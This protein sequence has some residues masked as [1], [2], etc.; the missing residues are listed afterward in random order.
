MLSLY[1]LSPMAAPQ[2]QS[3]MYLLL[4]STFMFSLPSE[5]TTGSSRNLQLANHN[6][7]HIN[8]HPLATMS[9]S[10]RPTCRP[11]HYTHR[12]I[13]NPDPDMLCNICIEPL[14]PG[15]RAQGCLAIRLHYRGHYVGREC[16]ATWLKKHINICPHPN[17]PLRRRRKPIRYVE[18]R[19]ERGLD[20]L[21]STRVFAYL[22]DITVQFNIMEGA[23]DLEDCFEARRERRLTYE[24][25]VRVLRVY[26]EGAVAGVAFMLYLLYPLVVGINAGYILLVLLW[27]KVTLLQ[28]FSVVFRMV[29]VIA[30]WLLGL[31]GFI[32]VS[33]MVVVIGVLGLAMWEASRNFIPK[34]PAR[35]EPSWNLPMVHSRASLP[36]EPPPQDVLQYDHPQQAL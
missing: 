8:H 24:Q 10:L 34:D 7:K 36:V 33:Y 4:T 19:L 9:H 13:Y 31:V 26:A 28:V 2:S 15:S 17:H 16:F 6:N 29:W 1:T 25:A 14:K 18:D 12:V 21:C 30:P 35:V 22:E 27:Q 3:I 23:T 32:A 11:A 20:Y 5:I